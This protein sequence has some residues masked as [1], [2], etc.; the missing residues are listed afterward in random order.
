VIRSFKNQET[1]RVFLRLRSRRLPPD[2]AR[3]ALRKL[4]LIHGAVVV[5]DLKVPPGNR[6]EKLTGDRAGQFSVRV[7]DQWRIC[8]SWLDG[9]AHDVEIV[10]Y[11]S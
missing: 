7:N 2:V 11:H 5:D 3:S 10:D 4:L 1:E 9:E 8:F 6:L